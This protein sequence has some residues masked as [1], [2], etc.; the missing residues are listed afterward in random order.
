[1]NSKVIKSLYKKEILDVLRDKKTLLMMI[2]VPLVLY[3]LLFLCSM[4]LA[5]S[6]M[7]EST[8][9]S[10][11]ICCEGVDDPKAMEDFIFEKSADYNYEFCFIDSLSMNELPDDISDEAK[12]ERALQNRIID[13][14]IIQTTDDTDFRAV[15][16]IY[17]YSSDSQ[18]NTAASMISD[19]LKEYG[20]YVRVKN[21]SDAGLDPERILD[22]VKYTFKDLSTHEETVGSLFGY[23]IPFLLIASVLMGAMYPAIDVTAGEKERGTLETLL[24]LPVKNIELIFS[25]FLATATV[26][27][28]AAFLNVLSMGIIG[29]YFYGSMSAATDTLKDFSIGVYVPA[30]LITLVAACLFAMFC[31][32]LCLFVCIFAKSFKEAQNYTTPVMVV[33]MLAG[34]AGM[35]PGLELNEKTVWIP[36]V[37]VALLIVK[38]FSFKFELTLII[39]VLVANLAYSL[40]FVVIMARTFKSEG[41]LFGDGSE[42]IHI[43]ESRKDMKENQIPGIGD[44]I[45][46]FS[47][48][49]IVLMMAGS[50]LTIKFGLVGVILQQL[51]IAAITLL[52]G[53][54][55]KTDFKK[56]FAFNKPQI[57]NIL[58]GTVMWAGAYIIMN[59]VAL[60]LAMFF[61]ESADAADSMVLSL[62]DNSNIVF[63][64][65]A[66]ALMPAV[67]E[68]IAF[69]GFLFGTLKNRYKIVTAILITGIIFGAY[70]MNFVKLFA[71]GILGAINAYCLYK[72]DSIFVP[73]WMHLLNNSFAMILAVKS[74]WFEQHIPFLTAEHYSVPQM[75][76][77]SVCGI[78]LTVVGFILFETLNNNP[79]TD[80][81]NS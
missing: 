73:M 10:Y 2:V 27:S 45:L 15:Y 65:I 64:L 42:G 16:E 4:Y 23:I 72:S 38:L 52:Y 76:V 50:L 49:L 77:L 63:I 81:D 20:E 32:A 25:K 54:Y 9:H 14:Y 47:V 55:I 46:L 66:T 59:I 31:S 80:I 44:L 26:A 71:V 68:E 40:I 17:F 58:A 8:A 69:R 67:C 35:L 43:I 62:L 19:M 41:I 3:P 12:Y 57:K 51:L 11:S 60:F 37:N 79:K 33:M 36:V 75:L 1:M 22:S 30:I 24:T 56:V 6:I 74:D 78:V 28:G 48:L 70:H 61:P 5:S 53:W 7:S 18:S 21:V 34:M 39:E 13:A 29:G